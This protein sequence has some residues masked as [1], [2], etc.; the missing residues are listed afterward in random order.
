VLTTRHPRDGCRAIIGGYVVRDRS[1]GRRRGRYLYGDLCTS[2]LSSARLR[3]SGA[4]RRR[5]E[6]VRVP[7]LVSFGE[8]A[9]GRVYAIS[10]AGRVYRIVSG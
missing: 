8:D 10:L 5:S 4:V 7:F 9:R 3:R 1:F 6:R 2:R